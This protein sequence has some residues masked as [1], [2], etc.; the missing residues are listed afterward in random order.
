MNYFFSFRSVSQSTN[1]SVGIGNLR[2]ETKQG[3]FNFI[4]YVLRE[5]PHSTAYV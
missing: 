1:T 3:E 4:S 5:F 2:N